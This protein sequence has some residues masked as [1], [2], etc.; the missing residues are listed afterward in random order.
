[1]SFINSRIFLLILLF[2]MCRVLYADTEFLLKKIERDSFNYFLKY[3][4]RRTGLTL[5]SSQDYAPASIAASGFYLASI[6]V[7]VENGWI[8]RKNGYNRVKKLFKTLFSMSGR[9]EHGFYYHFI[10]KN[11]GRR[12]WNSE[13]S[14]I[15]TAILMAGVIVAAEYYKGTELEK[16]GYA[17]YDRVDWNWMRNGTDMLCH[18]YKPETGFLPYYWDMYSE[19][20]LLQVL[21]LG[22]DRYSVPEKVWYSWERKRGSYGDYEVVY[23]YTGS[24]FTYQFPH[25]F[26]DFRRISDAGI[27]YF[28]NSV[29]AVLANRKFCIDNGGT[30]KTY[31]DGYWGLSASLGPNGYKAYGAFPGNGYHDGTVAPY[32]VIASLPFCADISIDTLKKIYD[33]ERNLIYGECGFKDAFNSGKNWYADSYLAIDQGVSVLMIENY[34]SEFVWK[35]FSKSRPFKKWNKILKTD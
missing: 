2:C 8:S 29:N 34:F 12:V 24:L 6:P 10:D 5:D 4:S 15:D 3:T 1:M 30:Y 32:A 28:L 23:S 25:A 31:A 19:H 9:R 17:L 18:G 16:K 26:V 13:L 20:L 35:Y 7:A 22:A 21:A 11:T 27:D 33:S 14:S